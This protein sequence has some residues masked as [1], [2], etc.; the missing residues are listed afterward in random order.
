MTELGLDRRRHMACLRRLVKR[1]D[2]EVQSNIHITAD[3]ER[4]SYGYERQ[5]EVHAIRWALR[6][7]D[8]TEGQQ[9]ALDRII[10]PLRAAE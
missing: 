4:N 10:E 3:P 8:P 5:D 9:Q 1:L 7:I 2:L 6:Q